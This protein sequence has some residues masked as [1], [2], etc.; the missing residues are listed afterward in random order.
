MVE[1]EPVR[2]SECRLRMCIA[3]FALQVAPYADSAVGRARI[4]PAISCIQI[5]R[6]AVDEDLKAEAPVARAVLAMASATAFPPDRGEATGYFLA[7][8]TTPLNV[9]STSGAASACGT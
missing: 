8:S 4:Q 2:F 5:H 9:F 3:P 6:D 1:E 7:A